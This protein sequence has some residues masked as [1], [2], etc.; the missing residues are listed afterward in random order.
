MARRKNEGINPWY[1]LISLA[2]SGLVATALYFL[3]KKEETETTTI[4]V[5]LDDDD[6]N[7]TAIESLLSGGGL[8]PEYGQNLGILSWLI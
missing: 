2:T 7:Q 4:E 6:E 3:L 8:F 1:I 5:N